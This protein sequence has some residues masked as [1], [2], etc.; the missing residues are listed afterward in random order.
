[1][2][3][4][5]YRVLLPDLVGGGLDKPTDFGWYSYDR[6]TEYAAAV[7]GLDLRATVVVHDWGGPSGCGSRSSSPSGSRESS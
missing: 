2:R 6:H 1:M 3:D 7:R 5:G 4:A